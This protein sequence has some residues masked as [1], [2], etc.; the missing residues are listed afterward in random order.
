[1]YFSLEM[2]AGEIVQALGSLLGGI[3]GAGGAVIAVYFLI[4]KQ[5]REEA[6]RVTDA[7]R[8][9]IVEFTKMLIEALKICE[10]IKSGLTVSRKNSHSILINAEPII[11][12]AVADRISLL[13]HPQLVVS[14]Y[15]RGDRGTIVNRDY[16]CGSWR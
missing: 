6:K 12:K 9:E 14:F 10:L 15:G 13:H 4:A 8:R 3:V 11:Y 5:R 2:S 7:V 1:M 16:S